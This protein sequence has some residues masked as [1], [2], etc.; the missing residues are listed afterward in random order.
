[1]EQQKSNR[2]I[3]K[4]LTFIEFLTNHKVFLKHLR[5]IKF[6]EIEVKNLCKF[7][8]GEQTT[9]PVTYVRIDDIRKRKSRV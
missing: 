9:L 4:F 8:T 5:K 3:Y 2:F 6:L 7:Q 1:M